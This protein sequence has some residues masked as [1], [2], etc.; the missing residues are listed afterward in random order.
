MTFKVKHYIT[1]AIVFAVTMIFYIVAMQPTFAFWDPGEYTAVSAT[2]G[3]PHPPG[4]AFNVLFGHLFNLIPTFSDP[5]MRMTL[6]T[7]FASSFSVLLT[8]LISVKVIKFFYG[9]NES[10]VYLI[11]SAI[12]ALALAFCGTYTFDSLELLSETKAL[13]FINLIIWVMLIWREKH[14]EENSD[15]YVLLCFFLL[16]LGIGTHL[17]VAQSIFIIIFMYYITKY[18]LTLKS[19]LVASGVT[20]AYFFTIFP[21]IITKIP[22]LL[23]EYPIVALMIFALIIAGIIYGHKNKMH[24][25]KFVS[26]SVFFMILGYSIFYIFMIRAG[27]QNL[28]VNENS[29][30]NFTSFES[31]ASRDQYG[32]EPRVWPRRWSDQPQHRATF[33]NY[34]SDMDFMFKYQIYHMYIRYL[35]WQFIGRGGYNQ[36]DGVDPSKLFAIPFI[37][38][39]IGLA[40]SFKKD[41]KT[42]LVLLMVFIAYGV[43]T[44]LYQNQQQ[45]QPRERDYFYI[46]SYMIYAIWIG[47]GVLSI[48]EFVKEKL[49]GNISKYLVPVLLAIFVVIININLLRDTWKHQN[50]NGNYLPFDYAYNILQSLDKDAILITNGD[51]D[52]FPLW[53]IQSAYGIRT[54]VR[55]VNLSLANADWYNLQLKNERPF[56]ALTVPFNYSNE[57]L[58]KLST[59]VWDEN[60]TVTVNVPPSAYPDT[61][62][63]KPDKMSFK[64]P[65]T[66]RQKQGNQTIT[67]LTA[68]DFIVIDMLKA[69]NFQRP[70]YFCMTVA[71]MYCVGLTD[72]LRTEGLAQRILPYK[73][74]HDPILSTNVEFMKKCLLSENTEIKNT[75]APG[76]LFR[77]T[78]N[79]SVFYDDVHERTV[80]SYRMQFLRLAYAL[81]EDSTKYGEAKQ[82]LD[83][84][85]EKIP[86]D[87]INIDYRLEYN[88]A[89]IYSRIQDKQK[90]KDVAND[91]IDRINKEMTSKT[92]RPQDKDELTSILVD[93]YEMRE[94]YQSAM[95]ILNQLLAKYPTDKTLAGK[96]D[97]ITEKMNKK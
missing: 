7:I 75:P 46:V 80:E 74:G 47:F 68:A 62:K 76:F 69:N 44:A 85:E 96:R 31:Y 36:D 93:L 35:S 42:A 9:K 84:M 56:G 16:G 3:V 89:N 90:A 94:D 13:M 40:F 65:A 59:D 72:Y 91:A 51:N 33:E 79:R 55:I 97:K 20:A 87:Y 95:N 21:G 26:A 54:D 78:N 48:T 18:D 70:I 17:M 92:I 50:R 49:S 14:T 28:P 30:S 38:G 15:R 34:S 64:V 5:G 1:G 4:V 67:A 37:I 66:I 57:A 81:S 23:G 39:A 19:F 45:S 53:A 63:I 25:L 10:A 27:T 43:A 24:V 71:D 8:Y 2:L 73:V 32:H 58:K 82:V 6:F 77:S 83:R 52:T 29:P 61:M 88:L 41:K 60:K 11:A 12:G 22:M 86:R